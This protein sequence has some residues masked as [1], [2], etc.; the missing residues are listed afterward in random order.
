MGRRRADNGSII[1]EILEENMAPVLR[2][3]RREKK[4]SPS[5][6]VKSIVAS[7]I[8]VGTVAVS[9]VYGYSSGFSAGVVSS[10]YGQV[11]AVSGYDCS[12][13]IAAFASRVFTAPS[14]EPLR[15]VQALTAE[16]VALR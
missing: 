16:P 2:E 4:E 9:T 12:A 7:A 5:L 6:L 11:R 8:I 1:A 10:G 13:E 14:R 15:S 3:L